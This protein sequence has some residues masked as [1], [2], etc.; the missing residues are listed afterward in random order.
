MGPE[1]RSFQ[2][3][4][5]SR[6]TSK[7]D[8]SLFTFAVVADSHINPEQAGES[9]PWTT[10]QLANARNRYVVQELNRLSPD[11]VIH[12]GDYV[13]PVPSLPT[14]GPAAEAFKEI[15]GTLDC[16]LRT[17][18]GNHDVG[19]KPLS[20]MPAATV[21]EDA[22][23]LYEHYF[24][25]AYSSFD[26]R[27][28]HFVLIN[29]SILNSTLPSEREQQIWLEND[30]RAN[31]GKRIF[32]FTHYPLYLSD[33]SEE[34]HYDNIDEPARSWLLSL[35]EQ[36]RIEAIFAGH[37]HNFFYNKHA[38]TECY[39]LP[40][41]TFV[42]QDY[43][44]FFRIEAGPEHG[45]NDTGKLGF[46]IVRVYENEH[47]AQLVRTNGATPIENG[48]H[49][50]TSQDNSARLHAYH[51]KE[52]F[53]APVGVHLRHPWT[54]VV[55]L[56]Y[57]GPLDEFTR[58]K[59]RNDYPL[60]ALWD[61]GIRKLRVPIGDLLDSTTRERMRAL[62]SLG[63]EF[64]VF[65]YGVPNG[66]KKETLVRHH[67]LVDVWEVIVP[68]R[69]APQT[70]SEIKAIKEK[71][72]IRTCLSKLESSADKKEEG[73]KFSHVV[74]HGFQLNERSTIEEFLRID[75]ASAAIDGFAFRIGADGSPWKDIQVL[76]R[77]ASTLN[78]KATA[79]VQLA[80]GNP[81]EA[82]R[83]DKVLANRVA[84]A[85][86]AAFVV[87]DMDVFI[88]TF[89]DIDRGYFVRHGLVDRRYNTRMAGHVFRHLHS[90]LGGELKALTAV[91][92]SIKSGGSVRVF[93]TPGELFGLLL[94]DP[95]AN[96]F[97]IDDLP[98]REIA[99]DFGTGKWIDLVTG[100]V[101]AIVGRHELLDNGTQIM[102]ESTPKCS[103]PSLFVIDR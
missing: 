31:D 99:N 93:E 13:H 37:V 70:A 11:F 30:L 103:G 98:V 44:E 79:T 69:E 48:H 15:F 20:W 84:E 40:S 18:P 9:S 47:V 41:V 101:K 23:G 76:S 78:I 102:L 49:V 74:N 39:T 42:R 46:F 95:E 43:S 100:E 21:S 62:K 66:Q 34:T 24:G 28:C 92:T 59:V 45:R 73:T 97:E 25:K 1:S 2:A 3:G 7:R 58:K 33:P 16:E 14:Y 94:P 87:G 29:A 52:N 71:A 53:P 51:T 61:L 4:V 68:W 60:L 57:N 50:Q 63:H 67:D 36:H 56:P 17:I 5:E 22:I 85:V 12:L 80:P 8:G 72:Q 64:T 32:L 86:A 54:E 55:E 65:T 83:D 77:L 96:R 38:D 75:G 10:N 27:D 19:D 35:V 91:E 6:T 82:N 88:D 26:H 89:V 81:A 90:V